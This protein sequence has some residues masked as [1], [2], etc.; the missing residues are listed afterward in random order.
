MNIKERHPTSQPVP[1]LTTEDGTG[2]A[3]PYL[4]VAKNVPVDCN[5]ESKISGLEDFSSLPCY[6]L[7][8]FVAGLAI[9]I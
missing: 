3:L 4:A 9:N 8:G 2:V 5:H 6:L 7:E 1:R